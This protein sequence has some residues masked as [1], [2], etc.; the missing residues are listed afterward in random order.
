VISQEY[1]L[2]ELTARVSS[3]R[4]W[5]AKGSKDMVQRARDEVD[6]ILKEHV[7]D[8]PLES[9]VVEQLNK[10]VAG[11]LSGARKA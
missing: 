7:P 1:W 4:E 10:V 5:E 11:S 6:R 2:P 3:R 9:S 8:P